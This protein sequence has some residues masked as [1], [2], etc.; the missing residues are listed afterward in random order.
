MDKFIVY[1][2]CTPRSEHP[3]L[4]QALRAVKRARRRAERHR[5]ETRFTIRRQELNGRE[6]YVY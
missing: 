5:L 2:F 6:T 1:N 4:G 3:T